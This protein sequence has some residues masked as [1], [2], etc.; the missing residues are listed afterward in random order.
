[1]VAG[2][3]IQIGLQIGSLLKQLP[4][5][6]TAMAE[7]MGVATVTTGGFFLVVAAVG[8]LI[9]GLT[10]LTGKIGEVRKSLEDMPKTLQEFDDIMADIEDKFQ[11]IKEASDRVAQ[12]LGLRVG[13]SEDEAK[14]IADMAKNEALM[15]E[16]DAKRTS[17]GKLGTKDLEKYNKLE[18]E[19]ETLDKQLDVLQKRADADNA[20]LDYLKIA[21]DKTQ[22]QVDINNQAYQ[23]TETGITTL[24]SMFYEQLGPAMQAVMID[25]ID[26]AKVKLGEFEKQY[27]D[28]VW[29]RSVAGMASMVIP[30]VGQATGITGKQNEAVAQGRPWWEVLLGI[31]S[32]EDP[33]IVAKDQMGSMFMEITKQQEVAAQAL[34]DGL[35]FMLGSPEKGSY[36]IVYSLIQAENEWTTMADL[37]VTEIDKIVVQLNKIPK[38]YTTIHYIKTVYI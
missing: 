35:G 11:T 21:N 37:A 14:L 7:M 31:T 2:T 6:K 19:N 12:N 5:L 38:S 32:D 26:E 33:I 23:D 24:T 15:A 4:V 20:H 18:A 3:Y 9:Y 34:S 30:G 16:L 27:N 28:M 22:T 8:A 17:T 10:E 25:K 13:K 29:M 1:M 36:P